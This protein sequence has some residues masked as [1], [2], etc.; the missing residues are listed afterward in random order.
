[1]QKSTELD[2]ARTGFKEGATITPAMAAEIHQLLEAKDKLLQDIA[3]AE[4]EAQERLK[5]IAVAVNQVHGINPITARHAPVDIAPNEL[6]MKIVAMRRLND[7]FRWIDTLPTP[8]GPMLFRATPAQMQ[9]IDEALQSL[10]LRQVVEIAERQ[11]GESKKVINEF[12]ASQ[13][14]QDRKPRMG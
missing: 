1:M 13:H 6:L 14:T 2:L 8:D 10:P 4:I 7:A 12:R 3:T 9:E 11:M 5:D